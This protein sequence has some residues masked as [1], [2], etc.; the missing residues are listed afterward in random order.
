MT[1]QCSAKFPVLERSLHRT[2]LSGLP[3]FQLATPRTPLNGEEICKIL[4]EALKIAERT[5]DAG[6]G[7]STEPFN[8]K[9]LQ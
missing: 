9:D 4:E 1:P 6:N 5:F 7:E 3:G 2:V 8:G